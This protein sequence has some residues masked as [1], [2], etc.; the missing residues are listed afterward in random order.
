MITCISMACVCLYV[1]VWM[2][3]C[4]I[5]HIC[6]PL[7]VCKCLLILLQRGLKDVSSNF[8][9]F[10]LW[11]WVDKKNMSVFSQPSLLSLIK[12]RGTYLSFL[13]QQSV[14]IW[15]KVIRAY[16]YYR[17]SVNHVVPHTSDRSQ[18]TFSMYATTF[19]IPKPI[20]DSP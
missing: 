20:S 18:S 1:C 8:C 7:I 3:V 17:S 6:W 16:N 5:M 10:V 14:I 12:C 4:V 9:V 2:Y 19:C 13:G 11:V 15:R